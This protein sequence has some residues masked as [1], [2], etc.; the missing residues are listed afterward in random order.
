M[1]A[2]LSPRQRASWLAALTA[3]AVGYGWASRQYLVVLLISYGDS[4]AHLVA[5]RRTLELGPFPGDL[6]YG[7]GASPPYYSLSHIGFAALS[8]LTGRPP[9][10]LWVAA[11]PYIAAVDLLAAFLFLRRLTGDMRIAVLG[12]GVEFLIQIPGSS[13]VAFSYPSRIAAVPRY[14]CWWAYL[15]GRPE[16][17]YS[18]LIASGIFLGLCFDTHLYVGGLCAIGLFFL[19]LAL[20]PRRTPAPGSLLIT[21]ATGALVASP[22]IANFVSGWLHRP[23]RRAGVFDLSRRSWDAGIRAVRN[24]TLTVGGVPLTFLEPSAALDALRLPLMVPVVLGLVS[25]LRGWWQGPTSAADRF[26]LWSALGGVAILFTPLYGAV[27]A[28]LGVWSPRL[29]LIF[30]FPILFGMGIVRSIDWLRTAPMTV[31]RRRLLQ[32]VALAA[33]VWIGAEVYRQFHAP[34]SQGGAFGEA[35]RVEGPMGRWDIASQ[36]AASG[37]IPRMILSDPETSYNLAYLL[38]SYVVTMPAGHGSPFADHLPRLNDARTFFRPN[39]AAQLLEKTLARYGVDAVAVAP[40]SEWPQHGW[41]TELIQR[42][43]R[44]P[45]FEETNCCSGRIIVFRYLPNTPS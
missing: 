33:F 14:L 38:G 20:A 21:G 34:I 37:P 17:R 32:V 12:A 42:L 7:S 15:R 5:I 10:E 26:V 4:W 39:A 9:H 16:R 25:C 19:D 22:W 30:P 24:W 23:E 36:L 1:I 35:L 27:V 43:R 45:N 44:N 2:T 18:W 29:V 8:W 28:A 3:I 11:P 40:N 31:A 13:W 6:F 41:A